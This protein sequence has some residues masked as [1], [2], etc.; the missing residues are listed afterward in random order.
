MDALGDNRFFFGRV[1]TGDDEAL[2]FVNLATLPALLEAAAVLMDATF[3]SPPR[4]YY[5]LATVHAVVFGIAVRVAA[6]LLTAK[7]QALYELCLR[8]L[9]EV[10]RQI[11]GTLF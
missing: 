2:I 5:Q 1:T 3:R 10:C 4:G 11:T 8:R 6:F 7:T 9:L